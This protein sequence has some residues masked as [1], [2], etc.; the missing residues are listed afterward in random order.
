MTD[1]EENISITEQLINLKNK[2]EEE[3]NN[4]YLKIQS[5]NIYLDKLSLEFNQLYLNFY[6]KEQ[7]I[8]D[9]NNVMH[10]FF[11]TFYLFQNKLFGRIKSIS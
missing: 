6:E 1:K 11:D 4:E 9:S 10:N 5:L 3:F 2:L 8:P 7:K